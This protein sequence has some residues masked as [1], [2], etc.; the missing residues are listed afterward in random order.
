VAKITFQ[1]CVQILLLDLMIFLNF[2]FFYRLRLYFLLIYSFQSYESVVQCVK[3]MNGTN[4]LSFI[5]AIFGNSC[6]NKM[7]YI[8]KIMTTLPLYMN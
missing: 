7:D 3:K 6:Y 5:L 2:I 4:K 8:M 1:P